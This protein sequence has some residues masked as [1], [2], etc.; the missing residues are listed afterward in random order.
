MYPWEDNFLVNTSLA[1]LV[2]VVRPGCYTQLYSVQ[3][4]KKLFR[5]CKVWAT[6]SPFATP[7]YVLFLV[8]TLRQQVL[9][10]LRG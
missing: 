7:M 10:R 9:W 4:E 8:S 2:A 6:I 1:G 5:L 3:Y